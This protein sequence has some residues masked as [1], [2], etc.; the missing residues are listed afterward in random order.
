MILKLLEVA[1]E[2]GYSHTI[3]WTIDTL[4]WQ[5]I[6][7]YEI[8][9]TVIN[10]ISPGGI[11]LMHTGSNAPGHQTLFLTSLPISMIEATN[12]SLLKK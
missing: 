6:S 10:N 7:S 5:G 8:S 2:E 11:V 12:L 1:G 3:M 9:R 4:D